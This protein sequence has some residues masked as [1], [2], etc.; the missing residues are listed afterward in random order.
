M[1]GVLCVLRKSGVAL[2][3]I[4]DGVDFFGAGQD[5]HVRAHGLEVLVGRGDI[6]QQRTT[7]RAGGRRRAV[8]PQMAAVA[9]L[10]RETAER[11]KK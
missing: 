10:M 6:I 5:A 9:V 3:L 1:H 2:A 4:A 11:N 7:H 8:L